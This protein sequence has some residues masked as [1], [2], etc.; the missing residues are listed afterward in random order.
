MAGCAGGQVYPSQ[1]RFQPVMPSDTISLPATCCILPR[2]SPL[3]SKSAQTKLWSRGNCGKLQ[4]SLPIP[5]CPWSR[6][7]AQMAL[8]PGSPPEYGLPDNIPHPLN[9]IL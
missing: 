2:R 9:S 7:P 4:P 6:N 8:P 1:P 3:F 5:A